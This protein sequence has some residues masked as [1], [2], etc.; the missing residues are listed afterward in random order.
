MQLAPPD[1]PPPLDQAL[2]LIVEGTASARSGDDFFHALVR[3]LATA[4]GFRFG[5]IGALP[6]GVTD[7]VRTLAVWGGNSFVPNFEYALEGTPCAKIVGRIFCYFPSDVKTQFPRD[8]ML[9]QMGLQSYAGA[10]L[11]AY[12]G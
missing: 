3:S 4:L 5:M 8:Q 2:R 11:F 6:P 1:P 9:Q 10:P 7:R 12:D